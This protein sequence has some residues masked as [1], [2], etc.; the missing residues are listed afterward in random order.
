MG[1]DKST[2][3]VDVGT[4]VTD[5]CRRRWTLKMSFVQNGDYSI[6]LDLTS[7]SP[8]L[9]LDF[10]NQPHHR[11]KTLKMSNLGNVSNVGTSVPTL[12]LGVLLS[13]AK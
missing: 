11:T 3:G 5:K 2:P 6:A 13:G 4:D 9:L 7:A 1:V 8:M 10:N 12:T